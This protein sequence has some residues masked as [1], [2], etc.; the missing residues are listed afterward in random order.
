MLNLYKG[1]RRCINCGE[2][3]PDDLFLSAKDN[4]CKL[5]RRA[6]REKLR[7]ASNIH[8]SK[9][10]LL[11]DLTCPTCGHKRTIMEFPANSIECKYCW[12]SRNYIEYYQHEGIE[13]KVFCL[14][15]D[16]AKPASEF[17]SG[18]LIC[19]TCIYKVNR[20]KRRKK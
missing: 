9:E 20:L 16:K 8:I 4:T 18:G 14:V 1:G 7:Y 5:C 12:E 6:I 11:S 17:P 15:C 3:K 10:V 2:K 19:K 13:A